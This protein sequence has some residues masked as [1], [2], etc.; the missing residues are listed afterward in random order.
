MSSCAARGLQREVAKTLWLGRQQPLQQWQH[1][2]RLLLGVK[3]AGE[4]EPREGIARSKGQALA[5]PPL[6]GHEVFAFGFHFGEHAHGCHILRILR[7]PALQ[8]LAR[9]REAFIGQRCTRLGEVPFRLRKAH[10]IRVS[11]VAGDRIAARGVQGGYLAPCIGKVR[12]GLHRVLERD[13][14]F[15]GAPL[16]CERAPQL[17]P[18]QRGIGLRAGKLRER[19]RRPGMVAGVSERGAKQQGGGGMS[20]VLLENFR[21]FPRRSRGIGIQELRRLH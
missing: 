15:Q 6:C 20:R 1:G 7:Q 9:R 10:E 5:E 13:H 2:S 18:R 12:L 17:Q 16:G 4:T 3:D 11:P 19:R 8:Q 14:R 21:R